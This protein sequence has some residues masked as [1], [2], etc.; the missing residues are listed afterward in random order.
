MLTETAK[1]CKSVKG[2][3]DGFC[4]Q[5][6]GNYWVKAPR[7]AVASASDDSEFVQCWMFQLPIGKQP[8]GEGLPTS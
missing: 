7:R 5:K 1:V 3:T 4:Q 8:F 6:V 2:V